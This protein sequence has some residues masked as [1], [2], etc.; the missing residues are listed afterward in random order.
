MNQFR[1]TLYQ[2]ARLMGDLQAIA[3]GK[4]SRF[5]KRAVNKFIGR[6]IV[7]KLWRK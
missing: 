2:M 3:S 1:S 7:S 4:P 5:A 6:K